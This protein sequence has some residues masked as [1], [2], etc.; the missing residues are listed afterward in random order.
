VELVK[1][2]SAGYSSVAAEEERGATA[3]RPRRAA[4]PADLPL[5][6]ECD[7]SIVFPCLN[8]VQSVASCVLD[9]RQRVADAGLDGEVI[10][11]DNGSSDGSPLAAQGAGAVVVAEAQ[12]GYGAAVAGGVA[13]ARGRSIVMLDADG[14][15]DLRAV[16]EMIARLEAGADL[17]MGNRFRGA[18]GRGAMPWAHRYIGSPVLSALLNLFFGTRVGDVHCGLRAFSRDA[19]DR[20]DLRTTGMEFA[21]EMVARAGRLGLRVEE[22]PVDYHPRT[23]ESKLRRYH[24]GWRHLRFLLMYSPTWLFLLPSAAMIVLGLGLLIALAISPIHFLGRNWDMHVS[25]LAS[26]LT[27]VGTQ[28]GWLGI[29]ARTVAVR[30][31]FDPDDP[32]VARFY[33]TFS[34]EAGLV[35]ACAIVVSGLVLAGSIVASWVISGF[36]ALD[37]IRPL[38]LAVT[39]ILVGVQSAFNAFFLSLLAIETRGRAR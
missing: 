5:G 18:I 39:L 13:V 16:G 28:L 12:R 15:Y 20:M 7:V 26:L 37:M 38:I 2:P 35:V 24:D 14:S 29:S 1:R 9:A 25:A 34:L 36:P 23:G 4:R 8:E 19:Y 11:S 32:V 21:S 10:V 31:G 3:A 30:G 22:V 17:V 6:A 27:L 33:R